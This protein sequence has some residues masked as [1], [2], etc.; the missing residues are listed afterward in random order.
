MAETYT[1]AYTGEQV[2]TAVGRILNNST[3]IIKGFKITSQGLLWVTPL[4]G[5]E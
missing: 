1:L 2:N 3:H 4:E 5:E